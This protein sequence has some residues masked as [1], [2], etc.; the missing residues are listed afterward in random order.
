[1]TST[2]T[3]TKYRAD[4]VGSLLRPP[5]LLEA[6]AAFTDG[7]LS[8][9]NLREIENAGVIKALEM[10][11]EAGI[12]VFT[13]GE[14]RRTGWSNPAAGAISGLVP[15]EGSPIR[16][17]FDVWRGPTPDEAVAAG[18][19]ATLQ[20][21][22]ALVA[23][24]KLHKTRRFVATDA[25]FLRQH[26]KGPW[27]ITLP[28][29]MSMAGGMYEPGVSEKAYPTRFDLA[30][31]L[32]GMI[33][34]EMKALVQDGA[35]YIQLDSL[36]YVER[37]ADKTVRPRML[38]EGE[39]PDAYLEELIR[40]DNLALAGLRGTPGVTVGLHMCRGNARSRWHAEGGYEPIAEK[41]FAQLNVDRFLLEY[42]SER[43]GGFDPLRFVP[44]DKMV[45]LGLISSKL[46]ELEQ[47]DYLRR[48]IEEA[49]KFISI[50][51]LAVSTQC[52]FAS[53]Q[54]GNLLSWDEQRRKLE[55]VAEVARQAF[56]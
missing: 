20:T 44:K 47:V 12:S 38:A 14:Y 33:N 30:Q 6:R 51:N 37:V 24:E 25:A 28:G 50:D 43:A 42:E 11:R 45:V 31:D 10:E 46:P 39:D 23:G 56:S 41:A 19:N 9:E 53:T 1:M 13:D 26:A 16:R 54:Q 8:E 55:L 36:H 3:S 49:T 34:D 22:R 21:A 48:R 5:E 35:P 52:G 7:K 29:P 32:A 4:H 15:V 40:L 17:I 27:K 18:V 2:T